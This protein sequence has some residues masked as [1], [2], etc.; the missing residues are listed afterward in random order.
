MI[1]KKQTYEILIL[2]NEFFN[3]EITQNKIDS[4]HLALK[5]YDFET[6]KKNL[7]NYCKT[8][9]FAPKIA[10][11]IQEK[12]IVLDRMNA[13]PSVEETYEYL[14]TLTRPEHTQE[15]IQRIEQSKAEIR[16]ILGL[17]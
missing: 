4:W 17:G 7:L 8:N 15:D 16:K 10:D 12:A 1:N 2:I 3:I 9:K 14:K 5:E 11:L 6:I 13:I